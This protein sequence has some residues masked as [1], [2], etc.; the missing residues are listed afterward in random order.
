MVQPGC[1]EIALLPK[2]RVLITESTAEF[3]AVRTALEQEIRPRGII[4]R[5]NV[6]DISSIVWEMLRLRRCKTAIINMGFRAALE[7]LLSQ[8]LKRPDDFHS[9]VRDQA[10]A[11][12]L[13]WFTD[14]E[15]RKR[16]SALLDQFGLEEFAIEAE[17]IRRS[18]SE[19]ESI[20]R[21]LSSL[22]SRRNKAL[23]CI[24]QYRESLGRQLREA[25]DRMIEREDVSGS[26]IPRAG[27][28]WYERER[29]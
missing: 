12:A 1:N 3:D 24:G 5:M 17:A 14:Q 2:Q 27:K 20:E 11:L 16:V 29:D 21:L 22:E 10:E 6:N 19:L 25:S 4:E 9:N 7:N 18:L 26:K 23:R 15:A 13:S 8:L 28:P